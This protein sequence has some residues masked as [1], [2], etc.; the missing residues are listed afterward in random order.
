MSI[1]IHYPIVVFLGPPGSGKGTLA[2]KLSKQ[3]PF[4]HLST[5][6]LLRGYAKKET[7]EALEL[8]NTLNS[9]QMAS[10]E[11][12]LKIFSQR[13]QDLDCQ[14][15]VILDGFPRSLEQAKFLDAIIKNPSEILFINVGLDTPTILK[16]LMGRRQCSN[17]S[18][19]YHLDFS[20]PEV[21]GQCDDC[22]SPL[23]IREDDKEE[24][25]LHRLDLFDASFKELKDYYKN[26]PCWIDV[27]SNDT[28]ER[29]FES[30]IDQMLQKAPHYLNGRLANTH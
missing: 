22:L 25:I 19:V 21:M 16:R 7:P 10:P 1:S 26:R 4:L 9:G 5:G 23:S 3:T 12:F 20:P 28:P 15:G 6:D 8:R 14:N 18:K 2:K 24:V 11:F 29:C 30:L 13:I 27:D 17:C